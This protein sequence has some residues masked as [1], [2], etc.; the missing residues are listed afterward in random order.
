MV[1]PFGDGFNELGLDK[2]VFFHGFLPDNHL[3]TFYNSLDCF[4]LCTRQTIKGNHV[5]GFGL[6][7]LEAQ[8]NLHFPVNIIMF[9]DDF[10]S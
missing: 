10:F 7:F 1:I 8:T 5:E 6:V 9:V 3:V 4:I 2:V